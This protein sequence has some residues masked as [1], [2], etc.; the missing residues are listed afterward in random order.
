MAEEIRV[1]LGSQNDIFVDMPS[2]EDV[3]K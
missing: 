3:H 2:L 1:G